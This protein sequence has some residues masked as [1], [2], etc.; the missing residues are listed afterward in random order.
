MDR[1]N[2]RDKPVAMAHG[3]LPGLRQVFA[4]VERDQEQTVEVEWLENTLSMLKNNLINGTQT[5]SNVE[6]VSLIS[7]LQKSRRERDKA[8][9]GLRWYANKENYHTQILH[10]RW[11]PIVRI[12]EDEGERAIS[13]LKGLGSP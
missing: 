5:I 8:I 10:E 11:G 1:D 12:N 6:V 13:I 3:R 4:A 7:D 9:E 2:Q